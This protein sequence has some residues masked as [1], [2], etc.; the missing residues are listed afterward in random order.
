M[1]VHVHVKVWVSDVHVYWRKHDM[2]AA[3]NI[4]PTD[5]G[6]HVFALCCGSIKKFR[7]C[8]KKSHISMYHHTYIH[9]DA[10]NIHCIFLYRMI[11]QVRISPVCL[12]HCCIR[13]LNL[14]LSI[15]YIVLSKPTGRMWY[16][17]MLWNSVPRWEQQFELV[18]LSLQNTAVGHVNSASSFT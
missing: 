14:S 18:S 3:L 15:H 16:F 6:V 9:V 4:Y 8:V 11:S 10:V 5:V 13:C 2:N 7:N 1:V 17:C 12:P